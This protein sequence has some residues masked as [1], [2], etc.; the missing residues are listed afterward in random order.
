MSRRDVV[1]YTYR[2]LAQPVD[3]ARRATLERDGWELFHADRE[4]A[5]FRQRLPTA[6]DRAPVRPA[7][8][9]GGEA[10]S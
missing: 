2:T 4:I 8:A 10:E 9:R 5:C 1:S 6:A 7:P 3:A